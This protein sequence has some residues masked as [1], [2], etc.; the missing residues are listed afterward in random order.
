LVKIKKYSHSHLFLSCAQSVRMSERRN[1]ILVAP[2][3]WGL[4]HATRCIPIIRQLLAHNFEPVLASDGQALALLRQE[5]PEL[6][7]LELPSYKIEYPTRGIYFRQKLLK[8]MPAIISAK[9]KEYKIV[10][11]WVDEYNLCGIISDNRLGVYSKKVPSVFVTH[12]L[13]VLSGNTTW[14]TSFVHRFIMKKFDQWWVPDAEGP[15][16]LSGRLGHLEYD[17]D[18]IRYIG[19]LSRFQK[20]ELPLQYDLMVLIS[21]PEPQRTILEAVLREE[22]MYF[23][24]SVIFIR[25]IIEN[26]QQVQ[27]VGSILFYNYMT[28]SELEQALNQ[29]N[30]V[31]CRSGYSTIMDLSVLGK[32]VLFIPTPG[33]YEQE[34][35][36]QKM[37]KDGFAPYFKQDRFKI[38][39]LLET[40]FYR[41]IPSLSKNDALWQDLF[42]LFKGE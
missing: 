2:L 29:S 30:T 6:T 24:G 11:K 25:G 13:N 7:L 14:L 37:K 23:K 35:L 3:N 19:A 1:R 28:S 10:E 17:E 31:I 32:K 34:Y 5:F 16:T 42:G 22:V 26:L 39:N 21:G 36:A 18:K 15:F 20:K 41:G 27:Q 8:Q 40:D 33:Q 9:R 12:Q 4:G 38:E